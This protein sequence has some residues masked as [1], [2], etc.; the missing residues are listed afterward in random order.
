MKTSASNRWRGKVES[1][2]EG[3]VNGIVV[4]DIGSGNKVTATVSMSAIKELG[5]KAGLNA[6]A[7]IKVTYVTVG[8]D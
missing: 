7:I 3:A 2:T 4:L 5:L 1:V 6:Y 8:M